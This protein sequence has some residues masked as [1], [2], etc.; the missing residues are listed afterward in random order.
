M[1]S[2][3]TSTAKMKLSLRWKL[4]LLLIIW[5]N[6]STYLTSL[7][8]WALS[9]TV[10][11]SASTYLEPVFALFL[12]IIGAL[13]LQGLFLTRPLSALS[14][15]TKEMEQ[16][17]LKA[18]LNVRTGDEFEL[19]AEGFNNALAE[20]NKLVVS[21]SQ[22]SN[23]VTAASEE[24]TSTSEHASRVTSE[25]G[26]VISEVS[27][28]ISEKSDTVRVTAQTVEELKQAIDQI[29]RG[30]QEQAQAVQETSEIMAR[31][32]EAIQ[33]T[34]R[35]AQIMASA[36]K[37]TVEIA[38]SGGST[39]RETIAGMEEIRRTSLEAAEKV[40]ELDHHSEKVGEILQV[41]SEIADQTNLLALNAAIEAARAGEHGKGFAVVADEVR[42]LAERSADSA[43]E[44]AQLIGNMRE[45]ILQ[46]VQAMEKGG[47]KVAHGTE[48]ARQAGQALN[49]IL[50]SLEQTDNQVQGISEDAQKMR[51]WLDRVVASVENVASITE[52]NTASAE[53]MA[54]QGEQVA[55]AVAEIA[56]FYEEVVASAEEMEASTEDMKTSN[57]QVYQS[58][59][60]LADLAKL[61]Q[62]QIG[63]FAL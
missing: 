44:I 55:E 15:F 47:E 40:R 16:G 45:G 63:K 32:S 9:N 46:A 51:D 11:A 37:Q 12:G 52:E 39:V 28:G 50:E 1:I 4:S 6:L 49:A 43:Q 29:A 34:A 57:E 7:L 62:D 3:R 5:V 27:R 24:L 54:A 21:M 38:Q 60:Q 61:L 8:P 36:S 35:N 20:L 48:L 2:D 31:M 13:V 33:N 26:K 56:T 14:N 17:N 19:I 30:A 22:V 53:Q 58:A 41:I 25:I 23:Q 42:K 18:K 10:L 59:Q